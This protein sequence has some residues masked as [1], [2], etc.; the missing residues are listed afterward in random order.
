[1]GML[2]ACTP[3]SDAQVDLY[4]DQLSA[5]DPFESDGRSAAQGFKDV[6]NIF[7]FLLINCSFAC[8]TLL[9]VILPPAID[10]ILLSRTF[11]WVPR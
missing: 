2:V 7:L 9:A 6:P 4:C 8:Y 3:R 1:M 11:D 10:E 5:P